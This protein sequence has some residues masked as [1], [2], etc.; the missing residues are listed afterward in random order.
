MT[1]LVWTEDGQCLSLS[2]ARAQCM[3]GRCRRRAGCRRLWDGLSDV[4]A[5]PLGHLPTPV[6][7]LS[8]GRG[9]WGGYVVT[10]M[11]GGLSGR[12]PCTYEAT[13]VGKVG[14]GHGRR[15][16]EAVVRAAH[17]GGGRAFSRRRCRRGQ[18]EAV[19]LLLWE[20]H[21]GGG[22]CMEALGGGCPVAAGG[23]LRP[24]T[25][26]VALCGTGGGG[27]VA[28]WSRHRR[29]GTAAGVTLPLMCGSR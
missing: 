24:M 21:K 15:I 6:V 28:G 11:G 2:R 7:H 23:A 12:R 1:G 13:P 8:G 3:F 17:E 19:A 29:T 14:V 27:A 16:V 9:G 4:V 10:A 22:R 26:S 20:A 25:V 18:R 5:T